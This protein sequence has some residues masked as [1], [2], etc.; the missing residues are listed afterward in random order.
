M[1]YAQV[2][3]LQL[4]LDYLDPV[5]PLDSLEITEAKAKV[6]LAKEPR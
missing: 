4:S 2:L 6:V 1:K 3:G 5:I